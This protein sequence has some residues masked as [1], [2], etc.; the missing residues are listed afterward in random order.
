VISGLYAN[1]NWYVSAIAGS[2]VTGTLVARNTIL[3]PPPLPAPLDGSQSGGIVL[4]GTLE[5]QATNV[6]R[7][8]VV[9]HFGSNVVGCVKDGN[10]EF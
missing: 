5:Q 4:S 8:N 2:D 9:G 7:D 3:S 10:T 6:C 1:T